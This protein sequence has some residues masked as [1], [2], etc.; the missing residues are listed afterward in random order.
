MKKLTF[1]ETTESC[2]SIYCPYTITL[3]S[4]ETELFNKKREELEEET[5]SED[6]LAEE[7]LK[8]VRELY[9]DRVEELDQDLSEV[10]PGEAEET[11]LE[12]EDV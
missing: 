12:E 2:G 6:E 8:Y 4:E 11:T 5:Y 10:Y 1:I 7:L 9:G 3:N